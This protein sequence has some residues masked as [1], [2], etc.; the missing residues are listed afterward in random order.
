M[1]RLFRHNGYTD[2]HPVF[3]LILDLLMSEI[4]RASHYSV[5]AVNMG[6]FLFVPSQQS[7][8]KP[9]AVPSTK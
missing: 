9:E 3:K 2:V 8:I 1:I 7:C 4:H 5:A 6:M